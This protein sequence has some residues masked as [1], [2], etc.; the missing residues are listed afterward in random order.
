MQMQ[1]PS[2]DYQPPA[3][4]GMEVGSNQL[5]LNQYLD[6][7]KG[8]DY[9]KVQTTIPRNRRRQIMAKSTAQNRGATTGEHSKTNTTTD[10]L[11]N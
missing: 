1:Y 3:I 2:T 4:T 10:M 7:Q 6:Y 5:G 9:K 11:A 8:T